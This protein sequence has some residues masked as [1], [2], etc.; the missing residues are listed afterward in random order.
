MKRTPALA[1]AGLAIGIA[2]GAQAQTQAWNATTYL[3]P[4]APSS[5]PKPSAT[6]GFTINGSELV[7][8]IPSGPVHRSPIAADGTVNMRYDSGHSRVGW[9]TIAGNVPARGLTLSSSGFPG[10][11]Y[12]LAESAPSD[13][14]SAYAGSLGD[15]ALGRWN[16]LQVRN[17][18]GVGLQS[19]PFSLVV[20]RQGSGKVFCRFNTPELVHISLWASRCSVTADAVTVTSGPSDLALSRIGNDRLDGTMHYPGGSAILRLNR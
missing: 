1:L 12:A 9:V 4:G 6:Y 19:S 20:E 14:P 10:C 16:G 11:L 5:C 3:Q 17:V 15:W 7:A 13:P 18:G 8:K 2:V